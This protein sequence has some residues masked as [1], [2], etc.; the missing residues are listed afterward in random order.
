MQSLKTSNSPS[1]FVSQAIKQNKKIARDE[2]KCME[3]V[4]SCKVMG[5]RSRQQAMNTTGNE[6]FWAVCLW[7]K[8]FHIPSKD[9]I[10]HCLNFF[11]FRGF[12]NIFCK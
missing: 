6:H 1:L 2:S 9:T 8:S 4:W 3:H 7:Q 10:S 5:E 11:V 12:R